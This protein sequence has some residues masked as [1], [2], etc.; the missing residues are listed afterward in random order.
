ML[1]LFLLHHG[2]NAAWFRAL[3]KG[4]YTPLR[5]LQTILVLLLLVSVAA[6]IV[7]GLAMARYALPFLNIPVSMSTARLLHLACGYWS[8]LLMELHLG[9]HWSVFLG[10]GRKLRGGRPLPLAGRWIL[11]TLAGA[12]AAWGA[13]CFAQQN[14]MDYLFL[15]TEFAFFDYEKSPLLTMGELAA[16]MVLWILAGYLLQRLT[17]R[18]ERERGF[19]A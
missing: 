7:S 3:S 19:Q 16:M 15:R 11:R 12:A 13:V 1:A 10:L 17:K 9:L 2:L 18:C 5:A 6:Q 4:R 8:F 14:I